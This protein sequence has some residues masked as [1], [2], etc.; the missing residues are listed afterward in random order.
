MQHTRLR[1]RERET[2]RVRLH[3]PCHFTAIDDIECPFYDKKC[4][5]LKDELSSP[6]LTSL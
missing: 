3:L 4:V 5:N 2:E 6:E 1:E